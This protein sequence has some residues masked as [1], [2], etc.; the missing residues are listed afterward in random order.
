[1][2]NQLSDNPNALKTGRRLGRGIGSTKGK[3]AG[4]GVKGYKARSGSSVKGFE[5]GQMPLY[6][7]LPKRGFKSINR[8]VIET[9]NFLEINRALHAGKLDAAAPITKEHLHKAG[10]IR[11]LSHPV[12]L[13]NKGDTAQ[14]LTLHV[15]FASA[16]AL[17]AVKGQGGTVVL[18][19]AEISAEAQANKK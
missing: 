17:E 12:K 4:R 6:Q 15:D 2:L 16:S 7:R 8:E 14:K 9:V 1:M 3:T 10:L 13:L 5:G 18:S 11:R 19:Q